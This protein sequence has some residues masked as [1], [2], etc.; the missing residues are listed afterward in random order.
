M[1][2]VLP[3]IFD[4]ARDR[5]ARPSEDVEHIDETARLDILQRM[6][7]HKPNALTKADLSRACNVSAAAITLLLKTPIPAGQTRGCRFWSRLAKAIG[8]SR[9]SFSTVTVTDNDDVLRRAQRILKE[10]AGKGD[11]QVEN[12]L[13]TGELIAGAKR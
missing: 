13:R 11:E 1:E 9:T 4:M 6:R 5:K 12:W 8:I 2:I 10:L 7:D 3:S